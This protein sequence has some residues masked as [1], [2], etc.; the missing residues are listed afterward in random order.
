M[1][2]K[3]DK[4]GCH[5]RNGEL[6]GNFFEGKDER[7]ERRRLFKSVR[8]KLLMHIPLTDEEEAFRDRYGIEENTKMLYNG[9]SKH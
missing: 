4:R 7:K 2:A 5:R 9:K 6:C 8:H 3:K 1:K